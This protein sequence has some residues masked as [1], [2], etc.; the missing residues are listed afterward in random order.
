MDFTDPANQDIL[1]GDQEMI[2]EAMKL[3]NIILNFREHSLSRPF[4]SSNGYKDSTYG[5]FRKVLNGRGEV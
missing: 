5:R 2:N 1:G 3:R 4:K